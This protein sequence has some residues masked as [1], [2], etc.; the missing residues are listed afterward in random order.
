MK[1][2]R[3]RLAL[4]A[5]VFSKWF[6]FKSLNF[7]KFIRLKWSAQLVTRNITFPRKRHNK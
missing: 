5:P 4:P 7:V 1:H 2:K 3:K 6:G